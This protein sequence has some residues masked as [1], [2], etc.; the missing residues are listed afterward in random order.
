[1]GN[2]GD[3]AK[4]YGGLFAK[5][6]MPQ[7]VPG[8]AAGVLTDMFHEWKID[9]TRITTDIQ[10]NRSL[11]HGLQEDYKQQLAFAAQRLGSLDF[12]TTDW[13][14][15]AIKKDFPAIA[16]L[17]LNWNMAGQWLQRQIDEIKSQIEEMNKD[18]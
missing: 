3:T 1:M 13:F 15:D 6:L 7:V 2:L 8:I 16:S 11:W 12:I 18:K 5:G 10:N 9:L 14:I 17:F 4:Y